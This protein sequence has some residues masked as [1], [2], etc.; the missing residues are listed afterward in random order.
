MNRKKEAKTNKSSEV[1]T[2]VVAPD[3]E[4]D[5]GENEHR[6][7]RRD[8]KD[9]QCLQ[10]VDLPPVFGETVIVVMVPRVVVMVMVMMVRRMR[11]VV[12]VMVVTQ[13][14][15]VSGQRRRPRRNERGASHSAII[16]LG[17]KGKGWFRTCHGLSNCG[18]TPSALQCGF[19]CFRFR[20][21][22]LMGI[23]LSF[24]IPCP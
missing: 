10:Q 23:V 8:K 17:G 18:P 11:I 21:L 1:Q 13:R 22:E 2:N 12:R 9:D 7:A 24:L 16:R 15:R 19:A 6:N 20:V 3:G 5:A 4:I 14:L